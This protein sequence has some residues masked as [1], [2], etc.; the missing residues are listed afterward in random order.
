M[1]ILKTFRDNLIPIIYLDVFWV[2]HANFF[3]NTQHL[4]GD[5]EKHKLMKWKNTHRSE[6]WYNT[7][8]PVNSII[9]FYCKMYNIKTLRNMYIDEFNSSSIWKIVVLNIYVIYVVER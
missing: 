7:L 8:K 2:S 1:Q 3:V 6:S 5:P 9:R 4:N